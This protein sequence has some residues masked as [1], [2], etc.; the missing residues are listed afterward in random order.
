MS[1]TSK[2]CDSKKIII[3][4]V[5]LMAI[6]MIAGLIVGHVFNGKPIS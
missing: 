6:T 4:I 5:I 1:K 2:C 3:G